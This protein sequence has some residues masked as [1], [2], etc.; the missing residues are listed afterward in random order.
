MLSYDQR[1]PLIFIWG[2]FHKWYLNHQSLKL[3]WNLLTSNLNFHSNLPSIEQGSRL[4]IHFTNS[5]S[6]QDPNLVKNLIRSHK[7]N[8]T[9]SGQNF[10]HRMTAQL[11]WHAKLCPDYVNRVMIWTNEFSQDLHI[12]AHKIFVRRVPGHNGSSSFLTTWMLPMC[13]KMKPTL[14][15]L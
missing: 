14:W 5:F 4:V 6:A 7:K 13:F 9:R 15:Y 2:H 8:I 3:A 12:W 10:A 1:G 11:S